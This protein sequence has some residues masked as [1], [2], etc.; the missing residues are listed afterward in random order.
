M[1]KLGS[2]EPIAISQKNYLLTP[3]KRAD[4]IFVSTSPFLTEALKKL[5]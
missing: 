2:L 3:V 4:T 1:G 5:K